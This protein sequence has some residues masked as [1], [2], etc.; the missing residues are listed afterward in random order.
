MANDTYA[1]IFL[2]W[3]IRMYGCLPDN[4]RLI[5]FDN[6]PISSEAVIPTSTIGQQID[7]IAEAAMELLVVQMEERKKRK[8]VPLKE[9]IHQV[10]TPVLISRD[11]TDY[12]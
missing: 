1:N 3:L 8:P 11:T 5:G 2:N 7:K 12:L 4:Y 9:P 10:V 6:S